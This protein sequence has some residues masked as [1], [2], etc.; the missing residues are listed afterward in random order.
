MKCAQGIKE[1]GTEATLGLSGVIGALDEGLNDDNNGKLMLKTKSYKFIMAKFNKIF[2]FL[3]KSW[4]FEIKSPRHAESNVL[5]NRPT[6]CN[7]VTNEKRKMKYIANRKNCLS[8]LFTDL[9]VVMKDGKLGWK[10]K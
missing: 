6:Y 7:L 5:K 2:H 9:W 3:V 10:F 4:E 8:G 1:P